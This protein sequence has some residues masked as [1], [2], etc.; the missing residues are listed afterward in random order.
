MKTP[1]QRIRAGASFLGV[2]FVIS[3]CAYRYLADENWISAIYWFVITVTGVGYT[4]TSELNDQM[5]I[6]YIAV[7][8]IG[9]SAAVYT[10][11]G[12][13]QMMT[14][15]EVE[16]ALGTLRLT[17]EIGR[18]RD[19]VI[20]CGY[21]RIGQITARELVAQ[22]RPLLIIENNTD[23]VLEAQ[24]A[25]HYVLL[26]NSTEEATLISA[27]VDRAKSLISGL[28]SDAD[29][30]FITLTS[31]NLN[32]NLQIITRAEQPSSEKK[33]LQAGADRVVL[34]AVIGAQ[35]IARMITRP[36]TAD[37][38]ELV[39]DA[40]TLDVELDEVRIS[41][42]TSLLGKTVGDAETHRKHRL[43]VVA[44][45][46]AGG[47]MVFNPDVDHRFEVGDTVLVMGRSEDIE[48]FC[49]TYSL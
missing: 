47:E 34:T 49:E 30:V 12:F 39:T 21:G 31:R 3:I 20:I 46:R 17:K 33:L 4:E 5:Q 11:G 24:D 26:G 28:P 43:L 10:I 14:E 37:L 44:A 29:N 35:R 7:I 18:L 19:H 42:N 40:K 32:P 6:L 2:V 38:I 23:R 13:L 41:E 36:H 25:G 8:A 15:G 1:L 16:R 22:D 27:G 45:R 48:Q 9:M